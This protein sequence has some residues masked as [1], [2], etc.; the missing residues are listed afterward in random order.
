MLLQG[1]TSTIFTIRANRAHSFSGPRSRQLPGHR[2]QRSP[3]PPSRKRMP[4]LVAQPSGRQPTPPQPPLLSV[5][6]LYLGYKAKKENQPLFSRLTAF[7]MG[8]TAVA[9]LEFLS[10]LF[11]E[12]GE[13]R[14]RYTIK[15]ISS[16]FCQLTLL[17]GIPSW[18]F[19]QN[20][21]RGKKQKQQEVGMPILSEPIKLLLE[22]SSL[23]GLP[24]LKPAH[25]MLWPT[26]PPHQLGSVT[27]RTHSTGIKQ[28][29]SV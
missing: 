7:L 29:A 8:Q 18:L 10:L 4:V 19:A 24:F 16:H 20:S 2:H 28:F 17:V 21:W 23:Q 6:C 22:T 13:E 5:R 15:P 26:L 25:Q 12:N 3:S 27:H 9:P 14:H 1:L 11:E